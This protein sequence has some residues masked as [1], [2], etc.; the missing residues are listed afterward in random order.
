MIQR[1][2]RRWPDL[3]ALLL[4]LS[5]AWLYY[6][7]LDAWLINDDEG[8]YLYAAW[9]IG[10]GELP[11]RD[12]L[13][14][15]LPAFLMPGGWLMA[16][17]G[18]ALGPTRALAAALT[19]AAG[20]LTWASARRLFGPLV[21]LLA[22]AALL[23]Q[24]DV[25]L[26]G[27][28]FRAD[29]F[30]LAFA[31]LGLYLFARAAFPRPGQ[32]DPPDRRWLVA[33]GLAFGLAT[34]SKLFGPFAL[35]GCLAWL[36]VDGWRRGRAWRAI[37]L[38]GLAAGLPCVLVVGAGLGLFAY[39]AGADLVYAAVIGHHT[40]QGA[41]TPAIQVLSSGLAFFG[42]FLRQNNNALLVCVALAV[43]ATAWPA[44]DR[45]ALLFGWQLPTAL[46]FLLL[47][48][49]KYPRH[50]VYLMPALATLFALG[51]QGLLDGAR[52]LLLG[53]PDIRS[54]P[55]PGDAQ[56]AT[57]L[58]RQ[59]PGLIGAL[60]LALAL[61]LLLPW[62][63]LDRDHAFR[64]ETGTEKLA[65]VVRLLTGPEE[66]LF[67]DY[68]EL[69]FYARRP[70]TYSAA[71]LSAG[72]AGSGQITWARIEAEL[73]GRLPPLIVL[74]TDAEYAHLSFLTDRPAFDAWLAEHYG[75]PAGFIQ[76]DYQRYRVYA[77]LDRPLPTRARFAGGPSLLAAASESGQAGSGDR[78]ELRTAWRM[79][80]PEPGAEPEPIADL[81]LTLRL[82]DGRGREWAQGDAGLLASDGADRLR[83]RPT[84]RW[85][86]GEISAQRLAITVPLGLP[87]GSYDLVLG[88]Y[89]RGDD[90]GAAVAGLDAFDAGGQPLG[91]SVL[92]GQVRIAAWPVE[93][94]RVPASLLDLD[95]RQRPAFR[96]MRP[97][98]CSGGG[99]CRPPRS[100][101]DGSCRST[102]GGPRRARRP[103][104][105]CA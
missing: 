85:R 61:A 69:N 32:I 89:R 18:P 34:L 101:P 74:D 19:L 24:P 44:R 90:A 1:L 77:P 42:A 57:R 33:A 81:G 37:L 88:L 28:S 8:S 71:S 102:S 99:R 9:R 95:L 91:Q 82:L 4:F 49:E 86:P 25:F 41:G 2:R 63:L 62:R 52:A 75:P 76:R 73:A 6:W 35:A 58:R 70:T 78:L 60:T 96:P 68:S 104:A 29:P 87:P 12:F 26:Q 50:L 36:L 15:Q 84:S 23:L 66:L 27:R 80:E 56:S 54:A 47:S 31:A 72:A 51:L 30:M 11:Y 46:I 10:L 97:C 79:P 93:A 39:I 45:R 40:R 64:W 17:L 105:P 53:A 16:W 43:A 55:A 67:S 14:P 59:L 98:A 20:L 48:R 22:G 92:V 103:T 7:R 5:I 100:R 94:D 38:D 83:V 3:L 13:T 21:A 65:D